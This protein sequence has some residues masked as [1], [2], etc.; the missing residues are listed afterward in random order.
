MTPTADTLSGPWSGRVIDNRYVLK[1]KLGEGG[2]GAVFKV[3]HARMGKV[4]ALKLLRPD[5][6]TD[7]KVKQRFVQEARVV[8]KLSHPNT[9]QVFDFGELPDGSLYI[10]MEYL[11]GRDLSWTLRSQGPFSEEK[12]LS[13]GCQVLASLAEA[14]EQGIIHRDV[15]PANVMLVKHKDRDDWIKVLDFG[16]AKLNEGEGRKHITGVADFI[17]TPAYMSPEQALGEELDARSDLYSTGAMLFELVSGHPVFEGAT[18]MNVVTKHMTEPPPRL[19]EVAPERPVSPAFEAAIRKALAKDK[20]DRYGSAD[21]MR[22]ALEQIRRALGLR[23]TDFTPL[24]DVNPAMVANRQDFDRFERR[25][26]AGRMAAPIAALAVLLGLGAAGAFY[27]RYSY[28]AQQAAS[29]TTE[30]EPNNDPEHANPIALGAAM[31]GKIGA[32]LSDTESDRDV[33]VLDVPEPTSLS[34]EL[35][36]VQD[37]NLVMEVFQAE[38]VAAGGA[39]RLAPLLV[40]DDAP[41]GKGERVDALEVQK[42]PLYV[43]ISERHYFTEAARPP[44]ETTKNE[45]HLI[46]TQ[47]TAPGQ[48][49]VEPDDAYADAKPLGSGKAIFGFTGANVPYE[50]AYVN[51]SPPLSTG[52]FLIADQETDGRHEHA[53]VVVPP[54]QGGL[55]VTDAAELDAW[56]KADAEGRDVKLPRAV[57]VQG[58]AEVIPLKQSTHGVR[59]QPTDETA[60]GSLYAVAFLTPAADGMAGV[61]DLAKSLASSGRAKASVEALQA[62]K[63]I[64][65]HSPQLGELQ[66]MLDATR[67]AKDG[68]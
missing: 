7:R 66:S 41:T 12:A 15:K 26:R 20:S 67:V 52:D 33:F 51:Q 65:P 27:Y 5:V 40:L 22:A 6:A 28:S 8:S 42:G 53:V 11:P 59:I 39:T 3:E 46:I 57:R 2:M 36:G 17:G 58:K 1:E 68:P 14:H 55:L 54:D 34:L 29:A 43:R 60:P 37:M 44:R 45:Y 10:A 30:R 63:E 25:L 24:P 9:I 61:L 48:M 32:P 56:R 62:A 19:V 47:T 21:E 50:R 38:A 64:Y 13:I 4:L 35:S 23:S 18:P 49:E 16:I 31:S